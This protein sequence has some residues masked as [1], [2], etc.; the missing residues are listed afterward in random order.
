[1]ARRVVVAVLLV[2]W[3]G[4]GCTVGPSTRPPVAVRGVDLPAPP[5]GSVST[6]VPLPSLA[7]QRAVLPFTDCTAATLDG[8]GGG[9]P[10]G[11]RLQ[12]DCGTLTVSLDPAQPALGSVTLSVLR[13]GAADDPGR[14]PLATRPPLL[15]LGDTTAEPTAHWA[16]RLAAQSPDYLLSQFA[17]I[18]LDRRGTGADTLDCADA[19]TR[20]A[21]VSADPGDIAADAL[22]ERARAVVQACNVALD[23]QL[24]GFSDAGAAADV[25]VVRQALGVAQL[26]AIGTGDGAAALTVWARAHPRA[27]GRLVLDGPPDP[28]VDE[29]ARSEARARSAEAAFDAFA[30]SCVARGAACPLG[31]DPRAVVTGLLTALHARP[32]PSSG[33]ATLTAGSAV[34]AIRLAL[35]EPSNWA[36]LADALHTATLGDPTGLVG[37]LDPLIGPRGRYDAVLATDCNDTRNRIAPAQIDDAAR[38]WRAA[39]PLFGDS[40]AV[41][42]AGCAPWPTGSGEVAAPTPPDLPPLAVIGTT[43]GPRVPLDASRALAQALPS[44][45]FVGWRG[46]G[47]GAFPRTPCITSVIDSLLVGGTLPDPATLCPP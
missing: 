41:D 44:A 20:A 16:A 12:A 31:T 39:Y 25:E 11:R 4:A 37:L 32:L 28:T 24:G 14:V 38:R 40:F 10:F 46:A 9:V 3:L 43:A 26:S 29:P 36:A 17:L 2:A 45:V 21:L 33:R 15:V 19:D 30:Q 34:A 18:G 23:G 5:L 1:M 42:L 6:P 7:P 8:L 22:L 47:T 35:G 27:V 13:I